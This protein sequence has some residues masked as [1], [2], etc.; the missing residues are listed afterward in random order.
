MKTSKSMKSV[1]P[2]WWIGAWLIAT[3]TALN[4]Q[5]QPPDGDSLAIAEQKAFQHA[6]TIASPCVVQIE[7]FGGL[8]RAD[9]QSV[10][11]GPIT[12]T[13]LGEEGWII[14]SLHS[15]REQ[16]ASILVS[17]PDST[18][19]SAKIVARDYVRELVLLKVETANPLPVAAASDPDA[20]QVGQWC[21]A[22][23]KTY[24][25]KTVTQSYGILSALGRAYGRAV[26]TDAKVSPINYGG[27][28]V[29]LAGK[30]IGIL[31]PI[32]AG[33]ML[34]DDSA[35]LYDSGIG[36]AVPLTDVLRRLPTLQSGKDIRV[37]KLGIVLAS[38]NE[39]ASPVKLSGAAPDSPAVRAGVKA[40]DV[41]VAV[42][43][44]KVNL[45]ADF[46]HALARFDAGDKIQ[47]DVRRG[48]QTLS[49]SCELVAEI[50]VYRKRY[51]GIQV[52]P[53][54][55]GLAVRSVVDGSPAATA[56][57]KAGQILTHGNGGPLKEKDDL[58]QILSVAD[59]EQPIQL[60]VQSDSDN[61]AAQ[62]IS[63]KLAVWPEELIPFDPPLVVGA[64]APEGGQENADAQ[65]KTLELKLTDVPN[66][67]HGLL[68]PGRGED[69][70]RPLGLLIVYS[71]P[72]E[73]SPDKLKANWEKLAKDYGWLIVFPASA[74]SDA[75]S[76]DE[77]E[78]ASRLLTRLTQEYSI[79]PERTALGGIGVGGKLALVAALQQRKHFR[80]VFTIGT[81]LRQFRLDQP[82]AP[83]Q[84]L[85]FLL[86]GDKRLE[87]IA[88]NLNRLGHV[89][90]FLSPPNL[91][92][93][94]WATVPQQ[95]IARW[96][97][98]LGY[99]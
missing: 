23:G 55:G 86:I 85:D 43:G 62:T 79:D 18:R 8:D 14:T 87:A 33:E 13:I 48:D 67:I 63:I 71:E 50:P 31:T 47:F 20:W 35:T 57:I 69:S 27:P 29:D 58:R 36:F 28:L 1:I 45:L 26:Q 5:A 65:V 74:S 53:A 39:M 73:L 42:D 15:L 93:D 16:P 22:I 77:T 91:E 52:E 54:A 41:I 44:A 94:K 89:A 21:I 98:F 60:A 96:L 4:T 12:G 56:G 80:G 17:L 84:T 78:L 11:S 95:Q 61:Q 19:A 25:E 75:W 24:D 88:G 49:L 7:T 68:P 83:L 46:K 66:K 99:F 3:T 2:L 30:V 59:L 64:A 34:G 82:S 70:R 32:S 40:G 38:T 90:N 10:A 76:R 51:L 72:G 81:D 92:P 37:G 6:V 97:E 9:D